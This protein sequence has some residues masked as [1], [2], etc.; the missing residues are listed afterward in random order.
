MRIG[1]NVADGS[2]PKSELYLR[3]ATR[4]DWCTLSDP[5]EM[6]KLCLTRGT[7]EISRRAGLP[8]ARDSPVRRKAAFPPEGRGGLSFKVYQ[9]TSLGCHPRRVPVPLQEQRPQVGCYTQSEAQCR[10]G[11]VS[12]HLRIVFYARKEFRNGAGNQCRASFF[13]AAG[14][15]LVM[16]VSNGGIYRA[17]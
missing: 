16:L 4:S 10:Q 8:S 6:G 15:H 17:T 13:D 9:P 12:N 5:I 11:G 3:P 7:V 2:A 14:S 1:S